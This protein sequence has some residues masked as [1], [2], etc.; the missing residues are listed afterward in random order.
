M[1]IRMTWLAVLCLL[2]PTAS[3]GEAAGD[4]EVVR[5]GQG[6]R[7]VV[8]GGKAQ[9]ERILDCKG[10]AAGCPYL[11]LFTGHP[12][13]EV[14]EHRHDDSEEWLHVLAGFGV[15]TSRGRAIPVGPGDTLRIPRG[16]PHAFRVTGDPAHPDRPVTEFRAVQV[17]PQGG[18]QSRFRQAPPAPV[19]P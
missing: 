14:P 17:F 16:V 15:M 13:L 11:G 7:R 5:A 6:D 12:G 10:E 1:K 4:L 18:P 3:A 8:A 2:L 9:V 19:T